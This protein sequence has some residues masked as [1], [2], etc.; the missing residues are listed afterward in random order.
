MRWYMPGMMRSC[1]MF[2]TFSSVLM[3]LLV[4]GAAVAVALIA[5]RQPRP[6]QPTARQVLDQR[7]A[8]GDIDEEE[9]RRRLRGL[10]G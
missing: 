4:I 2:M 3:W 8:R 1:F 5:T 9:Y 7:Y 6:A 10:V